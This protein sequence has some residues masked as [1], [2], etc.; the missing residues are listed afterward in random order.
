MKADRIPLAKETSQPCSDLNLL[1]LLGHMDAVASFASGFMDGHL[2]RLKGKSRG[3]QSS[4]SVQNVPTSG[5]RSPDGQAG[6]ISAS[7]CVGLFC[8]KDNM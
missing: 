2:Q 5:R 4:Q 8:G 1:S 7:Q 6:V 3:M